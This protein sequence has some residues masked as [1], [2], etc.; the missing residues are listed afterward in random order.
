MGV[1]LSVSNINSI[2]NPDA[3]PKN[4]CERWTGNKELIN[5]GLSKETFMVN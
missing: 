1:F 5:V 4:R 2:I 3:V